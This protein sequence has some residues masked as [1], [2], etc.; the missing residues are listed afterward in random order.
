[1][2]VKLAKRGIIFFPS[3]HGYLA[4]KN[5]GLSEGKVKT[6]QDASHVLGEAQE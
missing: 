1:M 5:V 6:M 4:H 2:G 3:F